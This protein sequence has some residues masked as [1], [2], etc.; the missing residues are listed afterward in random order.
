MRN[1]H[2]QCPKEVINFIMEVFKYND[3]QN[4]KVWTYLLMYLTSSKVM[5]TS[6]P[7][8]LGESNP[9][10]RATSMQYRVR[11]VFKMLSHTPM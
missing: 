2:K 7:V 11:I 6:M 3:N 9:I 4:N 5:P 10:M 8:L 1:M